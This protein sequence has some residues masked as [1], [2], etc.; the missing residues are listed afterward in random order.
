MGFSTKFISLSGENTVLNTYLL[1]FLCSLPMFI[2]YNEI[3]ISYTYATCFFFM[4]VLVL[5]SMLVFL[6]FCAPVCMFD[7]LWCCRTGFS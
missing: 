1:Y 7:V 6:S 2:C 4:F 3:Y 5:V